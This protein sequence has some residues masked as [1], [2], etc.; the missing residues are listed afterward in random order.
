MTAR[1]F[2]LAAAAG[3][4]VLLLAALGFQYLGGLHPCQ[5]CIWQRWPHLAAVLIGVGYII[6]PSAFVLVAGSLAALTSGGI[7]VYHAGV[8]QGW[9]AG[10][11]TCS[12][13]EI[14]GLST[15]ALLDQILSAP[16]T[17]CDDIVWS[18]AGLSMAGWNAVLSI[19]LGGLWL[20][21]LRPGRRGRP[22]GS[23][24]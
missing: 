13:G 20:I 9:W 3:S 6:A 2:A 16:V 19:L 11:T 22:E 23:R 5:M 15:E 12:A 10:P 7:G 21:A 17:R 18:F 8:E 14:G 1:G 4:A 24:G